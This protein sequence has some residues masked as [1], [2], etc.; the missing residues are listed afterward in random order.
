MAV[1][2]ITQ[3]VNVDPWGTI[4]PRTNDLGVQVT[5]GNG[6]SAPQGNVLVARLVQGVTPLAYG[7]G[8]T[9][10]Y[11][12]VPP[13]GPLS[14]ALP[15]L[16]QV[17]W[18]APGTDPKSADW[19]VSGVVTAPVITAGLTLSGGSY[20]NGEIAFSWA[21]A[22][23]A[24]PSTGYVQVFDVAGKLSVVQVIGQGGSGSATYVFDAT[25]TY[26]A[27]PAAAALI[28][29]KVPNNYTIG[30]VSPPVAVPVATPKITSVGFDG[31]TLAV[32]WTPPAAPTNPVVAESSYALLLR[33]S[34][35]L[36]VGR[37]PAD[38]GGGVANVDPGMVGAGVTVAGAASYGI[39]SGP[40]GT[41][42]KVL[43]AAP[44]I[45]NVVAALPQG[46]KST[47]TVT[48]VPLP[49]LDSAA[50]IGVAALQDGAV[51]ATGTATGT[52]PTATLTVPAAP[53]TVVASA[54]ISGT[55]AVAGPL[56]VPAP[57]VLDQ[58]LITACSA[59]DGAVEVHFAPG[60]N[61]DRFQGTVDAS[62]TS[63][64]SAHGHRSPLRVT[65][66]SVA[67]ATAYSLTV[68]AQAP[69]GLATGP[70][71]AAV[72][73]VLVAP[74]ITATTVAD[75]SLT[76]TITAPDAGGVSTTAY[77]LELMLDG[78]VV[79]STP[80]VV[81]QSGAVTL[82]IARSIDPAGSYSLRARPV[83]RMAIGP[84][85]TVPVIVGAPVMTAAQLTSSN[86]VLS[87]IVSASYFGPQGATLEAT[88]LADGTLQTPVAL[89]DGQA[90][91]PIPSGTKVCAAV[92][93]ARLGTA[94]VGPYSDGVLLPLATP[95]IG[96][97]FDA[98]LLELSWSGDGA[99]NYLAR[100]LRAGTTVVATIVRG[101]FT[102]LAFDALPGTTYT[103]EV[104]ELAGVAT[105]L[106]ASTTLLT[107]G[108]PVTAALTSGAEV[109]LTTAPAS[110][111]TQL[112]PVVIWAGT[113][114]PL[115]RKASA[116]SIDVTLP[117]GAAGQA[118]LAVRSVA[119]QIAG[120]IGNAIAVLPEAPA[121]LEVEYDGATINATWSEARDP[122]VTGYEATMAVDGSVVGQPQD[123]GL[124]SATFSYAAPPLPASPAVTVAVAA[125]AGMSK[126]SPGAT[127]TLLLRAP[128]APTATV[129]DGSV[130]VGWAA[131][132]GA[133]G[134]AVSF[135]GTGVPEA[136]LSENTITTPLPPGATLVAIRPIANQARGPAATL[137]LA[138][139]AAAPSI[140]GC[141]FDL[142][143]G[144]LVVSWPPI[145]G[146]DSY[147]VELQSG[148]GAPVTKTAPSASIQ[149]APADLP[150]GSP[151]AVRV[152]AKSG[153][154]LTGPW[155]AAVS[156]VTVAPDRV[157]VRYDGRI[158]RAEWLPVRGE[159]VTGYLV[160]PSA[161]GI[162]AVPTRDT[163]VDIAIAA[164]TGAGSTVVVQA[165]TATGAGLPS[166]PTPLFAAGIYVST[167]AT[168]APHIAP[169]SD[170]TF[171]AV[172]VVINLPDLFKD[173]PTLP[174][175]ATF[176][177]TH[178]SGPLPY[179]LTIASTSAAWTFKA[180]D[181]PIREAVKSDYAS[182]LSALA[183]SWTPRGW[184]VFQD[185]VGR[186]MPQT[187][188]ETLYYGCGFYPSDGYVDLRPGAILRIA[189]EAYQYVGPSAHH[190]DLIDGHVGTGV[191]EYEIGAFP[192]GTGRWLTGFDAFLA[193]ITEQGTVVP[194]PQTT[195][196]GNVAGGGGAIDLYYPAFRQPFFRI[197]YPPTVLGAAD[198][199]DPAPGSN[200]AIVGAGDYATLETATEAIRRDG[201]IVSGAVA[202]YLRG[203]ATL[204]A[205]MRVWV[206]GE[207]LVVPIGTTLAN[208]L[209]SLGRRPPVTDQLPV[210]G[211]TLVRG[212]GAAVI[213]AAAATAGYD[214]AGGQ[215]VRLDW[216][217]GPLSSS[218][219]D[220]FE[221]PLLPGDRL[222]CVSR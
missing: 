37:F 177:L 176:A 118:A 122:R 219:L 71:S 86:G 125:V 171:A 202:T 9:A 89:S 107:D 132:T 44:V 134:Y 8:G 123:T 195:P 88:V 130:T 43:D 17:Q 82:P 1:P 209:D 186:A 220:R 137:S 187:F 91:V 56:S 216:S 47:I 57:V 152:R 97:S 204:T 105:G 32:A 31:T 81:P 188:P 67:P 51:V 148:I 131:V 115:A 64:G 13:P 10:V 127:A 150:A 85:A 158:A 48:L 19:T 210:D 74:A 140:T 83:A 121:G 84:A 162:A 129:A 55:P 167:D 78:D 182:L 4:L 18:V 199:G 50:T 22:G 39:L 157:S 102:Q 11:V 142:A 45:S 184:H 178:G 211:L 66:S 33:S 111:V 180:E 49:G 218:G 155:S 214:A 34:G 221:L 30:S 98:G 59:D 196:A 159:G 173:Q 108:C 156:V 92:V 23:A 161:T 135:P 203:R 124:P 207:P 6:G 28:D 60:G 94:T 120:P 175:N 179:T 46:G 112:E 69:G 20:S 68:A 106:A 143:A 119:A 133:S 128:T 41:G 15:Y 62:G 183:A 194:N 53:L 147:T 3:V 205:C 16:V 174:T 126:G 160:T 168:L 181:A 96:A 213:D 149:L 104:T 201:S 164:A 80:G 113:Q 90:T 101:R 172:D 95:A 198:P 109:T 72:P 77:D 165:L 7:Q 40:A 14:A 38:A 42:P 52:P 24:Q 141:G 151:V 192:D 208:V 215:A 146:A 65:V 26:A 36:V 73:L 25:K 70:P 100:V 190:A 163:S 169:A 75:G 154:N 145:T 197:V 144:K 117:P 61:C 136:V 29:P 222:G 54:T 21:T 139:V 185:A 58:P 166:N 2:I 110:G 191:A 193:G 200:A 12:F 116:T 87:V 93:R 79:Q 153:A 114:T 5:V 217:A 138:A 103:A 76:A 212:P 27:Y 170:P 206:D 63:V 35:G 189:P 99:A